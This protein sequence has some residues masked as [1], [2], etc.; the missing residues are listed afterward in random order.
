MSHRI[1]ENKL[2][3]YFSQIQF[4]LV[5]IHNNSE[6]LL[7]TSVFNETIHYLPTKVSGL[8]RMIGEN[9][10]QAIKG[11]S[12]QAVAHYYLSEYRVA[13]M[14]AVTSVLSETATNTAVSSI[15][16]PISACMVGSAHISECDSV[17]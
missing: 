1:F 15:M 16:I 17:Y 5:H 11:S 8:S 7:Y 3:L 12:G 10:L 14:T 13:I 9:I 4:N 6:V 2:R